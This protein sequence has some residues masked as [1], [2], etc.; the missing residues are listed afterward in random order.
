M[1]S[2]TDLLKLT[3]PATSESGWGP[4]VNDQITEYIENA[5]AGAVSIDTWDTD[6]THILTSGQ[7]LAPNESRF[8]VLLLGGTLGTQG[9]LICPA[10]SKLYVI[11]ND[12]SQNVSAQITGGS[13]GTVIPPGKTSFLYCTGT[14]VVPA[15]SHITDL[16]LGNLTTD[17]LTV[18][19]NFSAGG[20]ITAGGN[21]N[22]TTFQVNFGPQIDTIST[23]GGFINADP[24]EL[25]TSLAIKTYVDNQVVSVAGLPGVLENN[26]NTAGNPIIISEGDY[27]A[28]ND[29]T[30][31]DIVLKTGPGRLGGLTTRFT[32]ASQGAVAL[33]YT[34][35]HSY[36]RGLMPGETVDFFFVP[37]A[38]PPGSAPG[39][40]DFAAEVTVTLDYS[41]T[42]RIAKYAWFAQ[43]NSSGLSQ[44]IQVVSD[45]AFG[46]TPVLIPTYRW[47][48]DTAIFVLA[49]EGTGSNTG[50]IIANINFL[51]Q[52]PL[53]IY[54]DAV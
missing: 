38:P 54:T 49:F 50:Q 40:Y 4:V 9:T 21:L 31:S 27:I 20:Q 17:A 36:F 35:M 33:K 48:G 13:T 2:Y 44:D 12:T 6:S 53:I 42:L 19:S 14:D 1:A 8:A 7:G 15:I 43:N 23:D 11:R 3:K 47:A 30:E 5:I 28:A 24:K 46:S 25:S 18:S 29:E 10:T 51:N 22:G 16:A 52:Y 32:I 26:N 45:N 34:S 39:Q 37:M 41:G